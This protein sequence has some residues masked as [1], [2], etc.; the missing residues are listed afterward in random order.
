[1][2][3]RRYSVVEATNRT[4]QMQVYCAADRFKGENTTHDLDALAMTTTTTLLALES[5][6]HAK[7]DGAGEGSALGNDVDPH[8]CRCLNRPVVANTA[9]GGSNWN[10]Q[11]AGLLSPL[12][13]TCQMSYQ[14]QVDKTYF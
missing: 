9:R 7:L 11:L 2:T 6:E 8:D 1:M 10:F 14:V 13:E 4:L 3:F 5:R 12:K